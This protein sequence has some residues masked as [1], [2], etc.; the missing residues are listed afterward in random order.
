MNINV[1]TFKKEHCYH[2]L[3]CVDQSFVSFYGGKNRNYYVSN[4]FETILSQSSLHAF[5]QL[6]SKGSLLVLLYQ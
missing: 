3:V 5:N 6:W 1:T 4:F 2:K